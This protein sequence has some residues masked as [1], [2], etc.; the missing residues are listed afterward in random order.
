MCSQPRVAFVIHPSIFPFCVPYK[1]QFT[2]FSSF[3]LFIPPP[4]HALCFCLSS[5]STPFSASPSFHPHL[6]FSVCLRK[7]LVGTKN[8]KGNDWDT[9]RWYNQRIWWNYITYNLGFISLYTHLS[10]HCASGEWK[11]QERSWQLALVKAIANNTNSCGF[12]I[13]IFFFFI[14]SFSRKCKDLYRIFFFF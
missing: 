10:K 7:G 3:L 2:P 9:N 11:D 8:K 5:V 14:Y 13:V 1:N 6:L 4:L 12:N